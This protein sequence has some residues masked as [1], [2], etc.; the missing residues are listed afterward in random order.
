M[1][2]NLIIFLS[3]V[4]VEFIGLVFI[5]KQQSGTEEGAQGSNNTYGKLDSP[6]QLAE[7]VDFY[8][9]GLQK[10]GNKNVGRSYSY[11]F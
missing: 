4:A 11:E 2:K 10:L 1:N 9:L 5:S 7:Y 3:V 6:V 8:M